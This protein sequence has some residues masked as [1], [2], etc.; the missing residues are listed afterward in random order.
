MNIQSIS[1]VAPT[2]GC[3]NNCG[4]CVSKM[5]SNNYSP[6]FNKIQIEK[7][8]KF[9]ANNGVNTAILTGT[10]EF[11]QNI[12]FAEELASIF[13]EM[14][15]PFPNVELQT[16]GVL[17]LKKTL[18]ENGDYVEVKNPSNKFLYENICLL[19]KLRVNTISLSI[20]DIFNDENNAS[21]IGIHQKLRFKLSDLITTLKQHDFNIRLSV[22]MIDIYDGISPKDIINACK[23]IGGNQITF[24]KLYQ[25][26][27]NSKQSKWV[28]TNACKEKTLTNI[29]EY[30]AGIWYHNNTGKEWRENAHGKP[31]YKLPFG[32]MAYS[33]NGMSTVIDNNCMNKEENEKLKYVI[34]R[35]NG[36][37]YSQ[38]DDEGSLIF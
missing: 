24:R 20:S 9:A 30:I 17:L 18:E 26:Y 33:I 28:K 1:I 22:N 37:L 14:N 19:K 13:E 10:G 16:T 32:A 5:H 25:S 2:K 4:Y 11:L 3:I 31:L 6:R 23:N 36:K 7:R 38:W 12:K 35:E 8:L 21:I 29:E 15:H 27:D 34:L